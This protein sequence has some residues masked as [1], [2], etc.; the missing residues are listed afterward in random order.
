MKLFSCILLFFTLF[1]SVKSF[2][3]NPVGFYGYGSSGSWSNHISVTP[4]G[5]R[6]VMTGTV[7]NSSTFKP[8]FIVANSDGT[9]V[10][11]RVVGSSGEL[12]SSVIK[13]SGEIYVVGASW[14]IGNWNK[15][16]VKYDASMNKVFSYN[17]GQGIL[18]YVTED[19]D[20]ILI[21]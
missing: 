18:R 4:D 6:L 14:G 19:G 2:S 1:I 15:L 5:T 12:F 16:V 7:D 13:Q 8:H 9:V 3:Q 10:A 21:C 11:D 17:F 20:L